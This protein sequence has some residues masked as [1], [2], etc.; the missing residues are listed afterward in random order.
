MGYPIG[1]ASLTTE[2]AASSHGIPVLVIE[3]AAYGA[4][5]IL[6]NGYRG[7]RGGECVMLWAMLPG[8]SS[9][10]RSAARSYCTQ[11]PE[12]PQVPVE[13]AQALAALGRGASKRRGDS[14]HYR[15]LA[16]MRKRP[17]RRRKTT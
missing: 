10:E 14:E 1:S 15:Q 11:W 5:D 16:A 13:P 7:M 4:G 2:H 6:P 12:G 8:R 9:A 3:G 17:G